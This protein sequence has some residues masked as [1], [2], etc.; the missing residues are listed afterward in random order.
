MTFSTDDM[1][2]GQHK[3]IDLIPGGNEIV[4]TDQNKQEY[5]AYLIDNLGL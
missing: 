4:V 5:I 2:F 3:I 1:V